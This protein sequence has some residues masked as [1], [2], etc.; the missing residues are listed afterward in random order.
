M[1]ALAARRPILTST[2]ATRRPAV[3]GIVADGAERRRPSDLVRIP[4][5]ALAVVVTVGGG[6]GL[7]PLGPVAQDLIDKLP[8]DLDPVLTVL[9][10][11]AVLVCAGA[12]VVAAVV[13]RRL[14]LGVAIAAAG[15]IG[16]GAGLALRRSVGSDVADSLTAG[17][18]D[19]ASGSSIYPAV[20][21][22][23]AVA[24]IAAAVP[25]VTRPLRRGMR[26]VVGLG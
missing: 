23:V 4:L 16:A 13:S 17:G 24:M 11:W 7:S 22:A 26:A 5:A 1:P 2:I 9:Y 8:G 12:V 6:E 18:L 15:L 3:F 20:P 25:Y 19:V 10:P 14:R 21:L